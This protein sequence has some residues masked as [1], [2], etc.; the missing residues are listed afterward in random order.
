[1]IKITLFY[2]LLSLFIG[3]MVLYSIHPRPKVIIKYPTIMNV[4]K[5]IYKDDKGTCYNYKKEEVDCSK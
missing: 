4:S 3:I 5:N 1:M 2:F